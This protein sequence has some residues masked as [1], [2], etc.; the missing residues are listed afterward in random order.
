MTA[1]GAEYGEEE[2][3]YRFQGYEDEEAQEA[4][5]DS[6]WQDSDEYF[7]EVS[8]KNTN[9]Y[10]TVQYRAKESEELSEVSDRKL[11]TNPNLP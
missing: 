6:G 1:V 7:Q 3:E 11:I 10:W 2:V 5:Y 4:T 8:G 9:R